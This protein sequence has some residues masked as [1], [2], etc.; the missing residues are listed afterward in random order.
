MIFYSHNTLFTII[1]GVSVINKQSDN[2][3]LKVMSGNLQNI[4]VKQLKQTKFGH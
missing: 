4:G 2:K 1:F 3:H